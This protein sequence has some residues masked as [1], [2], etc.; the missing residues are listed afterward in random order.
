MSRNYKNKNSKPNN[1]KGN[2]KKFQRNSKNAQFNKAKAKDSTFSDQLR[3]ADDRC[4]P[5]DPKF[6]YSDEAFIKPFANV[7]FN[8]I[9]GLSDTMFND[10][11]SPGTTIDGTQY[12]SVRL[13]HGTLDVPGICVSYF[14]P[15]FGVSEDPDSPINQASLKNY[16]FMR[17]DNSGSTN[18]DAVNYA[19]Y[20]LAVAGL[21]PLLYHIRRAI[22]SIGTYN[23][24]SRYAP[25]TLVSAMGFDPDDLRKRNAEYIGRFNLVLAKFHAFHV[26]MNLK[27]VRRWEW[28][29]SNVF[30]DR[31]TV[32][33]QMYLFRPAAFYEYDESSS[34]TPKVVA[35]Q[36]CTLDNKRSTNVFTCEYYLNLVEEALTKLFQSDSIGIMSGDTL[37]SYGMDNMFK[38]API[39]SGD[40]TIPVESVE[41]L[42]QFNNIQTLPWCVPDSGTEAVDPFTKAINS[43]LVNL[44][45]S[46]QYK[47][48]VD[49][50]LATSYLECKP[51]ITT[52]SQISGTFGESLCKLSV[53]NI[54]NANPSFEDVLE[55]TR[56][57][58]AC[59]MDETNV[60]YDVLSCGT[61]I[62]THLK[63]Y[64]MTRHHYKP[65]ADEEVCEVCTTYASE[66]P[67]YMLSAFDWHP[68][69]FV[70][71]SENVGTERITFSLQDIFGEI[72]NV[73]VL[74]RDDLKQINV[75]VL[76]DLFGL[77]N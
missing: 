2:D 77:V 66:S 15:S 72:D 9:N 24:Y 31:S 35:R 38:I 1:M 32:K 49:S 21:V 18:Y 51:C 10:V 54:D 48:V 45:H 70:F 30:L 43:N 67:T 26:P 8:V 50:T 53:M 6:Y 76:T 5:N 62:Y 3:G 33:A 68:M 44:I 59:A 22:T 34:D 37:K 4:A 23:P 14:I 71:R 12:S 20:T 17:H 13:A 29:C 69:Q 56:T 55:I 57:K 75:A 61:E 58:T 7:P 46:C 74:K 40:A 64:G 19:Q 28:M 47:E 42:W 52:T 36:I 39:S 73:T 63:V 27:F 41:A 25:D 65:G 16:A 11:V 60:R